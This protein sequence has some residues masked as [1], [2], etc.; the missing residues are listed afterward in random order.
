MPSPVGIP[1]GS[2]PSSSTTPLRDTMVAV[3]LRP[4]NENRPSARAPSTDSSRK[5]GPVADELDVG[6][7]RRFEVG[8]HRRPHRH[9]RVLGRVRVEVLAGR[10]DPHRQPKARKKQV[11]APV[12]QAPA[13]S[14]STLN[15]NVSP[16]QS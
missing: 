4:T 16:S 10:K 14:C 1:S 6:G 13:P 7:D 3:G 9:D 8:E 12:W 5:P 2:V 11:R 15:S